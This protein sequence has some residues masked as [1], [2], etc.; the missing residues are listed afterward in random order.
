[1][2]FFPHGCP[3]DPAPLI[4][5]TLLCSGVIFSCVCKFHPDRGGGPT[6][7]VGE[8]NPGDG[9][10]FPAAALAWM[11]WMG[12]PWKPEV[13]EAVVKDDWVSI[14]AW[15]AGYQSPFLPVPLIAG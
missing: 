6:G 13:K 11:C 7:W 8:E 10:D 14:L 12:L 5:K 3:F 2:I 15:K 4:V 1:M 9:G